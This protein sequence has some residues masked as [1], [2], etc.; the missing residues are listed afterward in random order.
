MKL[1]LDRLKEA[2]W[3]VRRTLEGET[4]SM[5]QIHNIGRRN[6]FLNFAVRW[7]LVSCR[8]SFGK[9]YGQLRLSIRS[10]KLS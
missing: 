3:L 10:K 2:F 4:E 1:C 9:S 5:A 8:E 6:Q 7:K